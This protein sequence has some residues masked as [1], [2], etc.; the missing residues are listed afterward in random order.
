MRMGIMKRTKN[1]AVALFQ[2]QKS[3]LEAIYLDVKQHKWL[4][5]YY[6][7]AL[8]NKRTHIS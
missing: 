7:K 1:M 2:T 4:K 8:P 6:F 5:L 3:K